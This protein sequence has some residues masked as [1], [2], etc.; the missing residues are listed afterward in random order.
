MR[1]FTRLFNSRT[2][3]A[4]ISIPL[5][6]AAISQSSPAP[7]AVVS[8][9]DVAPFHTDPHTGLTFPLR[10]SSGY[11]LAGT[12]TRYKY[13]FAKVYA[14]ALYV[15]KSAQKFTNGVAA[16]EAVCEGKLPAA[17]V[18]KLSR[19]VPSKDLAAALDESI[20]PNVRAVAAEKSGGDAATDLANLKELGPLFTAAVGDMLVIGTEVSFRWTG[21]SDLKVY[22][23]CAQVAHFKNVPHLCKGFFTTYLSPTNPLVPAARAAYISGVEAMK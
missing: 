22:V 19:N 18:M 11:L 12:A 9:V 13:G 3:S 8:R 10:D 2:L 1:S 17:M 6:S 20:A 14:V 5:A 15:D 21:K 16:L 7:A 23:N 4:L